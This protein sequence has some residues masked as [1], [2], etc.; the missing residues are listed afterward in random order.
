MHSCVVSV[1]SGLWIALSMKFTFGWN[2]T[3]CGLVI[4]L[5]TFRKSPLPTLAPVGDAA[6]TAET[7]V[8]TERHIPEDCVLLF[9]VACSLH[10]SSFS[11]V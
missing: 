11:L 1:W 5:P 9:L 6:S 4:C 2:M 7:L 8:R 10:N 3:P